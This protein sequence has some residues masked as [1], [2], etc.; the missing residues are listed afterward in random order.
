ME[1]CQGNMLDE[2]LLYFCL[3]FIKY[4]NRHDRMRKHHIYFLRLSANL[5]IVTH[6]LNLVY[7]PDISDLSF[8]VYDILKDSNVCRD[9]FLYMNEI[10]HTD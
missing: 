6:Y 5:C 8:C 3:C 9:S 7:K 2:K 4:N 1:K 10:D